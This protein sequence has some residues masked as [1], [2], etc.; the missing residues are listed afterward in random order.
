MAEMTKGERVAAAL[1]GEE[2]DRVPV[3][4]WYHFRLDQPSGEPLAEAELAFYRTYDLDFLKVMHDIP[5]EL[6]EGVTQIESVDD[7]RILK[8]LNPEKG[9]FGMQL[10][11]LEMI[12]EG[13]GDDGPV[14]DTVFNPCYYAN[15]LSG[16]RLMQHLEEHE[17]IVREALAQIAENLAA[18]SR[19]ALDR[20]LSGIY[21][22][23]S[24][25][26][27]ELM[28][29]EL[30]R[31]VFLPH[32]RTVLAAA[33][34]LSSFDVLPLHGATVYFDLA[35]ELPCHAGRWSYGISAPS[36]HAA[37]KQT[38]RCLVTGRA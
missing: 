33:F 34:P 18:Y 4:F 1:A 5:Y 32:D 26:S 11:A 29:E 31:D 38:E 19:A 37:P 35:N 3:S 30:Y 7:W 17:H 15:K 10:E 28:S 2:T 22:A 21:Y 13:R 27:P 14:L 23:L 8:P 16:G 36:S 25:A 6:P 20:G 24:G 9:H 12:L